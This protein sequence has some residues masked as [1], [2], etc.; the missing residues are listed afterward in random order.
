MTSLKLTKVGTSTGT[1]IPKEMLARMKV[2]KGDTLFAIETKEGYLITP[3]DPAIADQLDAGRE[4]M[5]EYRETFKALA[6]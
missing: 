1:I 6:K 5:K 3:Y 4:F 2:A